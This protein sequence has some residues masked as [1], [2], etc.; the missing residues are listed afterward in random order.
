MLNA[1]HASLDL[2]MIFT[3]MTYSM[4]ESNKNRNRQNGHDWPSIKECMVCWT[5]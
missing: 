1:V 5:L 3:V 2:T 4:N